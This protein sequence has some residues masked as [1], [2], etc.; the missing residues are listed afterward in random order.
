MYLDRCA[1]FADFF[2]ELS[3]DVFEFFPIKSDAR[4]LGGKLMGLRQR[5]RLRRYTIKQR[6]LSLAFPGSAALF[7]LHYFPVAQDG[8]RV[9]GVGIAE[10]V[11]MT[12]DHLFVN[13]AGNIPDREFAALLRDLSVKDNLKKQIAKFVTQFL[14]PPFARFLNSLECFIRFFQKHWRERGIGLFPIPRTPIG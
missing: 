14:G 12:A 11:W 3:E 7:G 8:S 5:R 10:N 9:V 1:Q 13:R 4:G 2:L 6:L